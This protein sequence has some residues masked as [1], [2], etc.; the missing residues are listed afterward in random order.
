[1]LKKTNLLLSINP[2]SVS[3]HNIEDYEAAIVDYLE[4]GLLI[5]IMQGFIKDGS[6]T[7]SGE[8]PLGTFT[9]YGL[10]NRENEE[11]LHTLFNCAEI[12]GAAGLRSYDYVY[13]VTNSI[14]TLTKHFDFGSNLD[15]LTDA[16][17]FEHHD[18]ESAFCYGISYAFKAGKDIRYNLTQD[19]H[20]PLV[21]QMYQ[22][23]CAKFIETR[24]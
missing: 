18:L 7:G 8:S 12:A 10:F 17:M 23:A 24:L 11:T 15:K 19:S 6:Y 20:L 1:M 16:G 14:K 5:T 2:S 9:E 22:E 13:A 4:N 21:D 3:H